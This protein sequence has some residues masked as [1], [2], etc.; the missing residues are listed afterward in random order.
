MR[1]ILDHVDHFKTNIKFGKGAL[2]N[3]VSCICAF[4]VKS[5]AQ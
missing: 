3:G 5:R 4:K 2:C 1:M